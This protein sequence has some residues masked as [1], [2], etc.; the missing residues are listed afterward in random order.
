MG[1]WRELLGAARRWDQYRV[2]LNALRKSGKVTSFAVL[3][4]E[5]AVIAADMPELDGFSVGTFH[6]L[7]GE[8]VNKRPKW[9]QVNSFVRVCAKVKGIPGTEELVR[10]W[11]EGYR[12]CGG[13]P[14]DHYLGPTPVDTEDA[15]GETVEATTDKEAMRQ[16]ANGV[17][18][19][20]STVEHAAGQRRRKRLLALAAAV[21]VVVAV[22]G[23]I[24]VLQ[25]FGAAKGEGK[26]AGA[27]PQV[28]NSGSSAPSRPGT[29]TSAGAG[30]GGNTTPATRTP[31]E[32]S[33]KLRQP[34]VDPTTD[35]KPGWYLSRIAWSDNRGT[36]LV[37][38]Y[39]DYTDS[40]D[41]RGSATGHGYDIGQD[42]VVLCQVVGRRI[43]LGA[44]EGPA[45]RNG[46]WYRMST[47][48]YIPAVYVDT[49]KASLPSC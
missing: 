47:G 38:A 3:A 14:G 4:R 12:R 43:S 17:T 11:A 9:E 18:T 48:E 26:S 25:G 13:D 34:A 44:Y 8:G 30:D 21:V 33:P 2:A 24:L 7:V 37:Q 45:E 49:T 27:A 36:T 1:T 5:S 28:S 29:R 40:D 41:G 39:A 22:G 15:V 10:L 32:S 6:G 31:K 23:G 35:S 42:I 19:E 46:L 16:L 20:G